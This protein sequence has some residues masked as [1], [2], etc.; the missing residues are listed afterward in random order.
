[1]ILGRAFFEMEKNTFQWEYGYLG[2]SVV[3]SHSFP[4]SVSGYH[5]Q[6][7]LKKKYHLTHIQRDP[8]I[9]FCELESFASVR[10]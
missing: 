1:M 10:M 6:Y 4:Q 7:L 2:E 8:T 9:L 3:L 5:Y